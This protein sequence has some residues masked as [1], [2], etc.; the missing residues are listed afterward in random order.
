M[1]SFQLLRTN[2]LLTT[3]FKITIDTSMNLYLESI[4]SNS[5]LNDKKYD[6]FPLNKENYLEDILPIFYDKMPKEQAFYVRNTLDKEIVYNDY[7]NQ[8]DDLYSS[9]SD[10]ITDTWYDEEFEYFAPLFVRK[11][12]L[13]DGFLIMRV[14]GPSSYNVKNNVY[15]IG[16]LNDENF[17]NEI[18]DKWKSVSYFDMTTNSKIGYWLNKNINENERFPIHSFDFDHRKNHFSK[19]YGM[20]YDTG[21]YTE[22]SMFL[23]DELS[24]EQPHFRLEKRITEGYKNNSI[25][26][27][28]IFN[29]NFLFEDTPATPEKLNKYTLN[30]Y[31]GFYV[32]ELEFVTNLT[33]YITPSLIPELN[34]YNNI[35]ISGSTGT[36]WDE[37]EKV[38]DLNIP[39]I[40]PFVDDWNDDLHYYIYVKDD[41]YQVVRYENEET[42][43]WIYKIISEEI[44]DDYWDT[45]STYDKTVEIDYTGGTYSYLKPLTDNFSVNL[46]TNCSGETFDMYED[47]YLIKI[48]DRFHVLK[49]NYNISYEDSGITIGYT[50]SSSYYEYYIQ[51]D[52][53]IISDNKTL[54]YW[55]GG[56]NSEYYKKVN[57]ENINRKPLV[58]S[59]FKVKFSD[60]KDF[61]FDR[62]ETNYSDFDYEKTKY[63]ETKEEKLYA[64]ELKSTTIPTPI[65]KISYG[66]ENQDKPISVSSEY[67]ATEELFETKLNGD[68]SDIWN[69]NQS[70][71]K[72]GFLGSIS[73]CDYPYKLNNNKQVG[74]Y[75]NKTTDVFSIVPNQLNKNLDYFYRIGNFLSGVT[76]DNTTP[77]YYFNQSTNIQTE[78]IDKIDENGYDQNGGK[79]FNISAYF[80][81]DQ[82]I[83]YD[84][85]YFNFFFSNSMNIE[86]NNILFKKKYKKYSVFYGDENNK[87]VTLFKGIKVFVNEITNIKRTDDNKIL[88]LLT[89]NTGK[90]SGYKFSIILNDVYYD[91]LESEPYCINGINNFNEIIDISENG[92]HVIINE[93]YKNILIIINIGIVIDNNSGQTFN[94]IDYFDERSGLYEN[95]YKNGETSSSNYDPML[96]SAS[97]FISAINDL[98]EKYGFDKF[99]TYYKIYKDENDQ[100]IYDVSYM[101]DTNVSV[102]PPLIL[103]VSKP[104]DLKVMKNS[105]I[106]VPIEGPNTNK[107][108]K[109]NIN[110]NIKS[111]EPLS[112]N[113]I[114]N[115][116]INSNNYTTIYRH[117]GP[118]E[119]IF[120]NINLFEDSKFCYLNIITGTTE[121]TGLTNMN[122]ANGKSVDDGKSLESWRKWKN[123]DSICINDDS[124]NTPPIVNVSVPEFISS[125][126]NTNYLVLNGFN[127]NIPIGSTINGITL[128]IKRRCLSNTFDKY[129]KDETIALTYNYSDFL[130]SM[131]DNKAIIMMNW[132]STYTVKTYG[133]DTD[134]WGRT[135]NSVD[136]NGNKFGVVIRCEVKNDNNISQHN[137]P[138]YNILPDISCVN[139]DVNYTYNKNTIQYSDSLYFDRNVKFDESNVDF[140]KINE[141]IYSKV[142]IDNLDI[143]KLSEAKYPIVDQFGYG[144]NDRFIFKSDWDSEFYYNTTNIFEDNN[145]DIPIVNKTIKTYSKPPISNNTM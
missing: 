23:D 130:H 108:F 56:N 51:S 13:P 71:C 142:N 62:V 60:I 116:N 16:S 83:N 133:G 77:V 17:R 96:I 21:V 6:H 72:W 5:A 93:N 106:T 125:S 126:T 9:G 14:D 74:S 37:C 76:S 109:K 68:I 64:K 32:D 53:G 41:L 61:D 59:I 100:T 119:P 19:W 105:F 140:G 138:I 65:K 141:H 143:L 11:D 86:K 29:L 127:F 132:T 88:K 123:I 75:F 82:P 131:S 121:M 15:E 89:E 139:V 42:N 84:F 67:L 73:H 31:F 129:A 110:D 20:D 122:A 22:K 24:Y 87:T 3:N 4:K 118:Y 117:F 39:S 38:F 54:E 135:W 57:I 12:N 79:N 28:H 81:V 124:D 2:P 1:K 107:L 97:N 66:L 94:Y 112:R 80:E 114:K 99:I 101:N 95:K 69:K 25:I 48:N 52:Y 58:Y 102:N 85:D 7:S 63:Y 40:N 44:L 34:L 113:I 115:G 90:Y 78:Y 43:E 70:I 46:Y 111:T 18:V 144:Y 50:D 103:S 91:D 26:Y 49:N 98:N 27:P 36:T 35:I 10:Y 145:I 47:L 30:R 104:I 134:D 137:P 120:K 45:G 8:F 136:I 92:I 128:N 55:I 33:S